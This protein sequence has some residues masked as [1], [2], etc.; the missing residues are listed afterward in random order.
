MTISSTVPVT[1]VALGAIDVRISNS[2]DDA[3]QA[4]TTGAMSL[5]SSDLELTLDSANQTVGMRFNA[6]AIPQGATITNAYLQFQ[7]D[8]TGST[9]TTLQ[10]FG[11]AADNP[12][13][14]TTA[15]SNISSRTKTGASVSW[16]PAAW[17]TIDVANA[18]QRTPDIKTVIQEII[19]R[20]GWASNNSLAIIITGTG[21]RTAEAYN[22]VP[23]AAPLLH[24]EYTTGTPTNQAPSVNAGADQSITLP[25][26][27]TLNGTV[28]DDG[29]PSG[30]LVTLWSQ[31]SGP[32]GGSDLCNSQRRRYNRQFLGSGKLH[33]AIDR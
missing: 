30:S 1:V 5:T 26:G 15:T 12:S 20:P 6:I 22:G 11:Q 33:A 17:P 32:V 27:A 14:F 29:L 8:E 25:N 10:I 9:A 28:T 19:S 18:A 24:V 7:A 23:A 21:R 3:E 2:S 31:I 13:T 4:V 16:S